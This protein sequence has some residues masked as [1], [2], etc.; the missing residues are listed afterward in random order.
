MAQNAFI[1]PQDLD[2]RAKFGSSGSIYERDIHL[3]LE[4]LAIGKESKRHEF[5]MTL[6]LPID[7]EKDFHTVREY[8]DIVA[9]SF[10]TLAGLMFDTGVL[11]RYL[12]GRT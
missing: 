5:S 12:A 7:V 10:D 8:A 3:K 1:I 6:G 4:F 2:L 9:K 11:K